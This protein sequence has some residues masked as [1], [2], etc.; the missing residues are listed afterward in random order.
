MAHFVKFVTKED[1][2]NYLD[3]YLITALW[4]SMCDGQVPVFLQIC[5]EIKFPVAL[6]KTYWGMQWLTF[7]GLLWT[8]LNHL[9]TSGKDVQRT[10]YD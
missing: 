2:V 1:L 9:H 5:H 7:L 4:K 10:G 6:E 3:D 8:Q